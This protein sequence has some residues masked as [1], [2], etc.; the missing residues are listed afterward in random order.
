MRIL[1]AEDEQRAREGLCELISS[2]GEKYQIVGSAANG[3]TA[4]METTI[5]SAI[6]TTSNFFIFSSS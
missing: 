1:I 3:K 4:S 6:K 5:A 2:L